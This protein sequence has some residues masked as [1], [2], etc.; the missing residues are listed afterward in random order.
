MWHLRLACFFYPDVLI[1]TVLQIYRH[2]ECMKILLQTILF[3]GN[4]AENIP[5]KI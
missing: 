4:L 3:K 1:A 2:Y 5:P